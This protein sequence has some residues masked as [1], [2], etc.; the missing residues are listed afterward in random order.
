MNNIVRWMGSKGRMAKRI[1]PLFPPHRT[2]V[3]PFGGTAAVLFRKPPSPVEVYNDIDEGLVNFFR[4]LRDPDQF[5]KFHRLACLTP[6]SRAEYNVALKSWDQY[7]DPVERAYRWFIIAR[8]G[9]PGEFGEGWGYSVLSTTSGMS[10][11]VYAWLATVEHLP[12]FA[13]RLLRVQVECKDF[14]DIFRTYDTP[15]TLFYCDPP[16]I[17][18]T[19]KGKFYQHELSDQDHEELVDILLHIQGM[20]VVSGYDHPIYK[21]LEEAGWKRYEYVVDCASVARTRSTKIL[22]RGATRAEHKRVEVV[23]TSHSPQGIPYRNDHSPETGQ[24]VR[25]DLWGNP[26]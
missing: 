21:P 15:E 16:Y 7:E 8:M 20:A 23:W 11:C 13:A 5:Q 25:L 4:V 17:L 24:A 26:G 9:I 19:R 18:S 6:Y 1:I 3:E 2:Y 14:R 22:G 10:R 12:E